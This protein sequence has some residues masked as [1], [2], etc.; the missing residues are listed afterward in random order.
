[1]QIGEGEILTGIAADRCPECGLSLLPRNIIRGERRRRPI[2]V[3][4]GILLLLFAIGLCIAPSTTAWQQIPGDI[5]Q[6]DII[7]RSSER[8]AP[9][10]NNLVVFGLDIF[11]MRRGHHLTPF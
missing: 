5:R 6:I 4:A 7:L 2:A 8:A 3:A 9:S 1:V 11:L 10:S